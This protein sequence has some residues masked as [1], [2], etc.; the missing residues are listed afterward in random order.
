MQPVRDSH[1][2]RYGLSSK[3][4]FLHPTAPTR[5]FL[6]PFST[7]RRL[8]GCKCWALLLFVSVAGDAPAVSGARPPSE[9]RDWRGRNDGGNDASAVP[10]IRVEKLNGVLYCHQF[11]IDSGKS[12]K[13]LGGLCPSISADNDGLVGA[14]RSRKRGH[15]LDR[16]YVN[17]ILMEFRV[18]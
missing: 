11:Q 3:L 5:P 17:P 4:A 6:R 14:Y 8:H 10:L 2:R 7:V 15:F 12:S 18:D 16:F 9:G 13:F 1:K